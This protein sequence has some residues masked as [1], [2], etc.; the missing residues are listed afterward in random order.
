MRIALRRHGLATTVNTPE[1]VRIAAYGAC[2]NRRL[3]RPEDPDEGTQAIFD[4]CVQLLGDSSPLM[5]R[6]GAFLLSST[7]RVLPASRRAPFA[8]VAL[9]SLRAAHDAEKDEVTRSQ[10][11]WN[12][13]AIAAVSDVTDHIRERK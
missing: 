5:R 10:L 8:P 6:A 2:Q 12:Y 3:L 13:D 11:Q 1:A 9:T 7:I 4:A